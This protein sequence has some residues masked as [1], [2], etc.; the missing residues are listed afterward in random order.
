M[1]TQL[2]HSVA[3]YVPSTV[4][5]NVPA[6]QAQQTIVDKVALAFALKF[7]GCTVDPAVTGWWIDGN[8]KPVKEYPIRVWAYTADNESAYVETVAHDVKVIMGQ[9]A[10]LIE[11]DGR[12]VL[13]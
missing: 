11:V 7:G 12:G 2:N 9:E 4:D 13:V 3:V 8:D 1:S 5:V 6:E 10:V